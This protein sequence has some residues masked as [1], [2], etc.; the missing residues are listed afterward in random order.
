V[1]NLDDRDW[2]ISTI[3]VTFDLIVLDWM[4]PGLD[5]LEVCRRLRATL[6][7]ARIPVLMLTARA[8]P[9]DADAALAAGADAYI[10]K[11]FTR[12]ELGDTI[13]ALLARSLDAR[14]PRGG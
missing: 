13:C 5:G 12:A 1:G 6:R 7:T 2:G 8:R 9:E 10:S 3:V 4:M 11:P 14:P